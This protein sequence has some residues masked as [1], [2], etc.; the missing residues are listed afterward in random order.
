MSEC[1]GRVPLLIKSSFSP[2]LL[3]FFFFNFVEDSLLVL[4][5]VWSASSLMCVIPATQH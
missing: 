5:R 2:V 1:V 3:F 4:F